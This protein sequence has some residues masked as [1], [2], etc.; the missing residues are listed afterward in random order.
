MGIHG[1][2]AMTSKGSHFLLVGWFSSVLLFA[3]QAPDG[4]SRIVPAPNAAAAISSYQKPLSK[5][6][7]KRLNRAI[8][9]YKLNA[10]QQARVR[11]ILQREQYDDDI[12]TAD[13][14]MSGKN[15]RD[16]QAELF[17]ESQRQI[18]AILDKRQKRKFD[19]DEK[20]RAWMD[21]RLPNPNPGPF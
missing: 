5:K 6:F 12:V 14:V 2:A 10:Q 13:K 18:G 1:H 7:Y 4:P 8:E 11:S 20:T 9:R 3:Q 15:K 19:K 16:E 21:G 17:E